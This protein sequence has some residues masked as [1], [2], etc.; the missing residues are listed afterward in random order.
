VVPQYLRA[1]LGEDALGTGLRA[2]PMVVGLFVGLR[3]TM[4]MLPRFGARALGVVGFLVGACGFV[5][6]TRVGV[7]SGYPLT[8]AW[9]VLVGAGVGGALF[10]GQN[11]ALAALPRNRAAAGSALVQVLR[12]VGSVAGIAVLGALLN[13]AYRSGLP[14][15]LPSDLAEGLARNVATGMAVAEQS[16]SASLEYAVRSAFVG[17]LTST[18]WVSAVICLLGA[19]MVWRYLPDSRAVAAESGDAVD[20]SARDRG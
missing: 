20:A 12:Q 13:V 14:T 6:G 18:M 3:L 8:A 10:C 1:V 5:L 16:G 17:G 11:G 2:V 4:M 15:G 9:T 7:D 19:A